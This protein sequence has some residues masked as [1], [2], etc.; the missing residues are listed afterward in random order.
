MSR[1]K[2]SAAIFFIVIVFI[3]AVNGILL[4]VLPQ[5]N[6]SENENRYL[7]TFKVPSPASFLDA[8]MQKNL[9]DGSNDQFTGRDWWMQLATAM[10]L[11]IGFQDLGGVYI[12]RDG[13]Y[14]ERIL[15][16][17]L[18]KTRFLNNLQYVEQFAVGQDTDVTFLLVPSKGMILPQMLPDHAVLYNADQ[19]F[20]SAETELKQA[21]LLDIRPDLENAARSM[22]VYFKT[23]HHW[24]ME[25]AYQAY[26]AWQRVHNK[27]STALAQFS[28]ECVSSS[29]YGT[30]YSKAPDYQSRPDQLYIPKN[31]A[32]AQIIIGQ[33][34]SDSIYDFS[35]L[36]TKDK[37]SVYF[38]G[39]FARID[40]H[41]PKHN[42]R[43][44]KKLL[45]IKDSFANSIVPF[46]MPEFDEITMLDL[47]YYNES[48]ARLMSEIQPDETLVLYEMSNF[49]QDMN[50]FK[51]LK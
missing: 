50:I 37:Y 25:A 30:L 41:M 15:D 18:S 4:F 26:C 9:T 21:A 43:N 11:R 42:R 7:T 3:L 49:A 1:T 51:I 40:I 35:R 2:L 36:E 5:R 28:P 24:T 39:N 17:D 13:Y 29:F 46:L 10:Q 38:G 45:I 6:Y 48:V 19:M 8:S 31:L 23:D 27:E 20:E 34:Q 14:F 16:S 44:L 22:Q 12:G 47:R 32:E 33:K